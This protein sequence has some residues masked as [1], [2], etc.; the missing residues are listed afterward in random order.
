MRFHRIRPQYTGRYDMGKTICCF[1]S[2][3]TEAI[4]L[5]QYTSSLFA[6]KYSAKIKFITLCG[7]Y[8]ILFAASLFESKLINVILY[9]VIN[10]IFL[11]TQCC[12]NSYSAFFH[13][14][15]LASV[16]ILCE[17]MVYYIIRYFSPHFFERGESFHFL[18]IFAIFSKLMFFTVIY[19]LL[20]FLKGLQNRGERQ[21]KSAFLLALI[22]ITSVFVMI[23][24]T[25]I[26]DSCD[27][28]PILNWMLTLSAVF[29]L[30]I[31]L[32]IF[33]I[34]QYNRKKNV[35][36]TEMQLLFQ[37]ESDSVQYYEMLLSQHENQSILIHDIKKHLQSINM[38][39]DK[40]EHDKINLYI[41]EL[42]Q[43]SD[44]KES[45]R[46]CDHEILNA[47]LARYERQCLDKHIAFHADI[48]S[49][50][51]DF[52]A[53]ADITSLFCNLLDNAIEAACH[54]S[55]S[56][57][58]ISACKREKTPFVVITIV[59]SSRK[60]PFEKPNGKLTTTKINKQK[61]GFGIKSIQKIVNKYHGDMQMYYNQESLTFHTVITL[62][63]SLLLL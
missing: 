40:R 38:L 54:I 34:E 22:P 21:D 13:S 62:K 33:G 47:I 37:K 15:I 19:V 44:L 23:T 61:H 43:S 3:L 50:I 46:L 29:L 27:L 2:F 48:R 5:W 20:H 57:I 11:A 18:A 8:S 51:I 17:V 53:D 24:F 41:C 4:I 63:Q 60:N 52:I 36:F 58:E 25:K 28:S 14:S 9:F 32:L 39:N 30:A 6:Y 7:L 10:F 56:F 59:N 45:V 42:M 16:M 12:L 26:S 31:N 55:N 1:F 49:G 35:E